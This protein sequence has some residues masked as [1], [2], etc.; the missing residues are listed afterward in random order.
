MPHTLE[1]VLNHAVFG[2]AECL[3][4]HACPGWKLLLSFLRAHAKSAIQNRF[5]VRNA[6]GA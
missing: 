6:K 5:D 1:V 4:V 2:L 3:L